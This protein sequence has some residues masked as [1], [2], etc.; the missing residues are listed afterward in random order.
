MIALCKIHPRFWPSVSADPQ[1][2]ADAEDLALKIARND[3]FAKILKLAGDAAALA[4][5]LP[6]A[7]KVAEAEMD[8]RRV[9]GV[10]HELSRHLSP[11]K[12]FGDLVVAAK[13]STKN[14]PARSMILGLYRHGRR[15]LS[16]REKA[17]RALEAARR[18][19]KRRLFRLTKRLQCRVNKRAE[20]GKR[21]DDLAVNCRLSAHEFKHFYY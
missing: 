21:C 14:S 6:A 16:R 20:E 17:D 10:Q 1:L 3:D 7:R 11:S 4:L 8:E 18:R 2:A 15:M 9:R 13:L 12:D 19:L 5:I